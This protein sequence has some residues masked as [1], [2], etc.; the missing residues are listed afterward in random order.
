MA[1]DGRQRMA[2]SDANVAYWPFSTVSATGRYVRDQGVN[3]P[4]ADI[5]KTTFMTRTR[6]SCNAVFIDA[7]W[8]RLKSTS[9]GSRAV[10]WAK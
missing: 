7:A 2:P 6:R 8:Q 10:P 1:V 9:I 4:I 5:V 3:G